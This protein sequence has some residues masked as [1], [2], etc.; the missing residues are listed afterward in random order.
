MPM[1]PRH[2]IQAVDHDRIVAAIAEAETQTSGQIRVYISDQRTGDVLKSA[3][4]S[5]ARLKMNRTPLRNAV[6]IY[7][8]PV[9][10]KFAVI[11]DTAVHTKCGQEFWRDVVTAMESG[12]KRGEFTE[13]L[14]EGV[15][16]LGSVLAAHF[17]P[18][19][20]GKNDLSDAVVE[21]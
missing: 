2:F 17:P 18:I 10:H 16:K 1:K 13:A 12:L 5:F 9:S 8:A 15:K 3:T 11:G 14:V 6:L 4:K 21:E 19:P 7:I 20:D